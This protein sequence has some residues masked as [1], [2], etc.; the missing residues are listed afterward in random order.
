LNQTT[1]NNGANSNLVSSEENNKVNTTK[2]EH[3]RTVP[4]TRD[5]E[6]DLPLKDIAIKPDPDPFK[7]EDIHVEGIAPEIKTA[8][9]VKPKHRFPIAHVNELNKTV[10]IEEIE[11]VNRIKTSFAFRRYSYEAAPPVTSFD[12]GFT[13]RK[14]P[15][16]IFPLL[17]S[18]Q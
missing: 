2:P 3:I 13:D 1:S 17:N 11:P 14:K 16:S 5:V 10:P 6:V 18:S 4:N 15:K 8:I 12:E 9:A 7:P